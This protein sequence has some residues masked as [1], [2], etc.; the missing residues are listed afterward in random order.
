MFSSCNPKFYPVNPFSG[1]FLTDAVVPSSDHCRT[2][3]VLPPSDHYCIET[4]SP[5]GAHY[6]IDIVVPSSD[7]CCTDRVPPS[8]D[9]YGTTNV[10]PPSEHVH[11]KITYQCWSSLG[12][13]GVARVAPSSYVTVTDFNATLTTCRLPFTPLHFI[14]LLS[15]INIIICKSEID[16]QLVNKYIL[17]IVE[18]LWQFLFDKNFSTHNRKVVPSS[19]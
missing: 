13:G 8:T 2:E 12:G 18:H 11:T 14:W 16:L 7:H 3:T 5:S 1:H 15:E 10:A 9:Q 6:F 17:V 19:M 4:V